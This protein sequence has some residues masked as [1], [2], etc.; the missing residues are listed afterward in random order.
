MFFVFLFF[1]DTATTEIYTRSIV[2]SVRCVQE[3]GTWEYRHWKAEIADESRT[4][5]FRISTSDSVG[6]DLS[7]L[8]LENTPDKKLLRKKR[9]GSKLPPYSDPSIRK[10]VQIMFS[11]DFGKTNSGSNEFSPAQEKKKKK[12][13]KKQKDENKTY[14]KKFT[15]KRNNNSIR[16]TQPEPQIYI[17][18]TSQKDAH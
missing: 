12:K 18:N 17:I 14:K 15:T 4:R 6:L 11:A 2:G 1:N 13:K 10:Q 3:T 9:T 7:S 16:H 8:S 5:T